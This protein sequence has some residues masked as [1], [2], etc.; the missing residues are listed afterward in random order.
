MS[1]PRHCGDEIDQNTGQLK[2]KDLIATEEAARLLNWSVRKVQR[3][4]DDLG[5]QL[6]GRG[7]VFDRSV[8]ER[9]RSA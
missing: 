5:G 4:K 7:L 6:I 2:E 3:H 1:R 9:R 8:V